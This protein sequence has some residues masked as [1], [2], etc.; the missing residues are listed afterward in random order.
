MAA[1]AFEE[2][3]RFLK[4]QAEEGFKEEFCLLQAACNAY[5]AYENGLFRVSDRW[6]TVHLSVSSPFAV[7]T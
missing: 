5:A 7:C 6:L 4:P 3:K 2:A 1:D